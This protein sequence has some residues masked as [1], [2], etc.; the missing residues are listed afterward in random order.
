MTERER[1]ERGGYRVSR[2]W[3]EQAAKSE[4][5][6]G[7]PDI[8]VGGRGCDFGRHMWPIEADAEGDTCECGQWYRF[9]DRIESTTGQP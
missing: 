6:A 9:N 1:D 3:C 7:D 2:H 8:T 5:A 4:A